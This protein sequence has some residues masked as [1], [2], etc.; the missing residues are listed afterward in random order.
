MAGSWDSLSISL[1][2]SI[3]VSAASAAAARSNNF[4]PDTV[5][6]HFC[7]QL[8]SSFK[9]NTLCNTWNMGLKLSTNLPNGF[10]NDAKRCFAADKL[11][12]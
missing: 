10:A 8:Q 11:L 7:N 2:N 1:K 5:S 4:R 3:R 9:A 12:V 6:I